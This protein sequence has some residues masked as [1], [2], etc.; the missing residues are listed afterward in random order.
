MG[1]YQSTWREENVYKRL[2]NNERWQRTKDQE[3]RKGENLLADRKRGFLKKLGPRHGR[4]LGS[5][6]R[7]GDG[8]SKGPESG[9]VGGTFK[10]WMKW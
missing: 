4:G 8:L 3:G 1:S 5:I 10:A 2:D 6:A 9:N 7:K